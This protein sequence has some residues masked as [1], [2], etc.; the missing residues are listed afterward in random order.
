MEKFELMKALEKS[1]QNIG[2]IDYHYHYKNLIPHM[3]K[4]K[5]L[6]FLKYVHWVNPYPCGGM[7]P[8]VTLTVVSRQRERG[9]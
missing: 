9:V 3:H 8:Y 4:H 2:N 1:I 7:W 5:E 6:I